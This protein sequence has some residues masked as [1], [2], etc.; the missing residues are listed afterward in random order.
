M[1][2]VIVTGGVISGV[3]KGIVTSSIGLLLKANGYQVTAVKIDPYLNVDAGTMSPLEHGECY[4]L[5]DGTETDL[6]LGNYERF[7]QLSLTKHHSITTGSIYQ[8]VIRKERAGDY[9][10]KTVQVVPHVVDEIVG[11]EKPS[12]V[13]GVRLKNTE[14]GAMEMIAVDGVFVAIG[15]SPQTQLFDGLL[16]MDDT[17]YLLVKPGTTQTKVPGVFAAGDVQDKIYRQAVT[18]AGQGCMAALEAEKY[19]QELEAHAAH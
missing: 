2:Y 14:T 13:T 7:L 4:V 19:L 18:A 3:G 1:K 11:E 9:L 8:E 17:G 5:D 16:D 12:R 15:H 10:G 6:D